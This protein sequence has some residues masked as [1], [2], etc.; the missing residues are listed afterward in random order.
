MIPSYKCWR[1]I[2]NLTIYILL[3]FVLHRSKF[4]ELHH[5]EAA[6]RQKVLDNFAKWWD[7][8]IFRGKTGD[9]TE[10]DFVTMLQG[11]YAA[12]K[13]PF[14]DK[15]TQC[16]DFIFDVI[17]TNKDRAISKEEF[18][19]AFKAYGQD[20][21]ACDEKFFQAFN[22]VDGVV[23]IKD[24]CSAWVDF[25]TNDDSSKPNAVFSAISQTKW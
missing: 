15:I 12:G 5:L 3:F 24:I 4:S 21:I 17:D 14:T 13:Q 1:V 19:I 20:K 8:F 6:Q 25:V 16:M 2:F 18:E 10:A 23:P 11:D 9:I 22:P 7:T